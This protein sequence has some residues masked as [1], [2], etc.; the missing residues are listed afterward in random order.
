MVRCLISFSPL[1]QIFQKGEDEVRQDLGCEHWAVAAEV[2]REA[3]G[4]WWDTAGVAGRSVDSHRTGLGL[5]K[6]AIV[7]L[8]FDFQSCS[9]L[10]FML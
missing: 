3:V 1:F 10:L 8:R 2:E 6:R 5:G 9:K 4:G 7:K